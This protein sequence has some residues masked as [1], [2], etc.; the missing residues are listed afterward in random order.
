MNVRYC[1]EKDTILYV[2]EA[3]IYPPEGT[4]IDI[5]SP[6][7][8]GTCFLVKVKAFFPDGSIKIGEVIGWK[9]KI[10]NKDFL[11]DGRFNSTN[12]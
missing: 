9:I 6:T 4:F 12:L 10:A 5:L 3:K 7:S 2:G 8:E 1:L 11:F